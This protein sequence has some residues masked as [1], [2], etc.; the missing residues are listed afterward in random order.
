L[1]LQRA[2]LES[3]EDWAVVLAAFHEYQRHPVKPALVERFVT[4]WRQRIAVKCAPQESENGPATES[5]TH[6]LI[7]AQRNPGSHQ[8][9][10]IEHA[11]V[12]LECCQRHVAFFQ[13][14]WRSL[15]LLTRHLQHA[16]TQ[17]RCPMFHSQVLVPALSISDNMQKSIGNALLSL[18]DKLN[19]IEVQ[20]VWQQHLHTLIPT[21]GGSGSN[22]RDSALWMKALSSD[23]L[24]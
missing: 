12:W 13:K 20:P 9:A 17:A 4:E 5:W 8:D 1:R 24:F 21:P 14:N 22:Y 3:A 19:H 7:D 18:G 16:E 11:E 15:A 6:R 10:F 23:F 2:V